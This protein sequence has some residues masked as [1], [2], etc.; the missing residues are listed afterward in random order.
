MGR[1]LVRNETKQEK[2]LSPKA[3][4]LLVALGLV[5]FFASFGFLIC[6][7][8]M[9]DAGMSDAIVTPVGLIGFFGCDIAA[10]VLLVKALP[11]LA[12]HDYDRIDKKYDAKELTMLPPLTKQQLE[13]QLL[14][15]KFQLTQN[16]YYC[17]KKFSFLKDFITYHVRVVDGSFLKSTVSDE[18]KYFDK[19]DKKG[20]NHCLLLFVY[21][22]N[23]T[24]HQED[25]LRLRSKQFFVLSSI[26]P[27][28]EETVMVP[29][30]V[31]N[32]TGKGYYLDMGKKCSLALYHYGC[33]ML[34]DLFR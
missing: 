4:Y 3:A 14:R 27:S 21:T 5:L 17:R 28:S 25:M 31:D 15:A 6:A 10:I 34:K 26:L 1:R 12:A 29:I 24:A 20:K 11:H 30:A 2:T 7:A 22:E 18:L 8:I 19:M 13:A 23:F 16:G 33:K 32:T 9:Q